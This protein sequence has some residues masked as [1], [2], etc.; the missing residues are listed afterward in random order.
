MQTQIR[1]QKMKGSLGLV[2]VCFVLLVSCNAWATFVQFDT[3]DSSAQ[4]VT[5]KDVNE[6]TVNTIAGSLNLNLDYDGDESVDD[7]YW[8]YCIE[9]G[10][11]ASSS[12]FDYSFSP[13]SGQYQEAAWLFENSDDYSTSE[14]QLAIW[15]VLY[16]DD[17]DVSLTSGD[18]Y[19]TDIDGDYL[20]DVNSL[21]T[22]LQNTGGISGFDFSGY[23]VASYKG[24]QDF[25]VP[26]SA[27]VPEPGTMFLL[28][29]GLLGMIGIGRRR[30]VKNR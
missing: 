7:S 5:L 11:L 4:S 1:F 18:F 10:D 14:I 17:Y 12:W 2:V 29:S 25:I 8:S 22:S 20:S 30:F 13:I 9:I 27:P 21:L 23:S 19:A 26:T 28:G 16:D 15:E 3:S 24:Q 6:G